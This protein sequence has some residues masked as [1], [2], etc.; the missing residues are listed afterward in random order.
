[1]RLVNLVRILLVVAV[2]SGYSAWVSWERQS[3][4]PPRATEYVESTDIPLWRRADAEALWHDPSTLFVDVR[5]SIDFEFGH[6]AGAISLPEEEIEQRLP[7]LKSSLEQANTIVVY[8]KNR[9]CGKSL[10]AAIRLRQAGLRQTG[11]Y[12]Q[13]WNDWYLDGLP[14]EGTGR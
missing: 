9:D 6:I 5:S 4:T 13:G 10:W 3:K 11:I 12:P 7:E 14:T 8:C 1:M 2:L